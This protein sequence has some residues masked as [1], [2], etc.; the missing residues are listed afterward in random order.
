MK[1]VVRDKGSLRVEVAEG[2]SLEIV[3]GEGRTFGLGG[4]SVVS[5]CRCGQSES[6]LGVEEPPPP[7]SGPAPMRRLTNVEYDNT[8]YQLFKDD[9]RPGQGFVPEEEANGFTNQASAVV[10]SPLLG[11]PAVGSEP[12]CPPTTV[13]IE[14]SSS[15]SPAPPPFGSPPSP[16]CVDSVE[17]LPPLL[18][19]A[20]PAAAV[21][22]A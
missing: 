4:R 10:V 11:E 1:I 14:S 6:K 12:P 18:V 22:D 13:V 17:S 3:D 9:T 8:I 5:L 2:E 19:G 16:P 20:P 15:E 7:S 21:I